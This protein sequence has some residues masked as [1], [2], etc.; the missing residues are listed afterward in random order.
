M[1]NFTFTVQI[2]AFFAKLS[3]RR[4]LCAAGGALSAGL[5]P[6][7]F[8]QPTVGENT[9]RRESKAAAADG[10]K[11]KPHSAPQKTPHSSWR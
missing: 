10:E 4:E 8:D 2:S 5:R 11:L 3:Q 7:W 9:D 6:L 1:Y